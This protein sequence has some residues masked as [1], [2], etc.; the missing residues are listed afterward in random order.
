MSDTVD[1]AMN[2]GNFNMLIK[3]LQETNLVD[4]LRSEGPFTVFAPSDS[5]F[6]KI[7]QSY[8]DEV[9]QNTSMLK[10]ILLYHVVQGEYFAEDVLENEQ[11][12]TAQGEP[13]NISSMQGPM[14]NDANIVQTDIECDNGVIHVI[15]TILMPKVVSKVQ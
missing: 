1:T 5:A 11:L 8:I 15:D 9:M 4:T 10:Q 13:L 12:M 2:A 14:V 7:P 3:A 6:M